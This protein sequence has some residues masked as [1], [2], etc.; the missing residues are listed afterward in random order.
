MKLKL[1]LE[2]GKLTLVCRKDIDKAIVKQ[3]KVKQVS[4][5][6]IDEFEKYLCI[7]DDKLK[8]ANR[9]VIGL[10]TKP[11]GFFRIWHENLSLQFELAHKGEAW[12][13]V[14]ITIGYGDYDLGMKSLALSLDQYEIV[15]EAQKKLGKV[16]YLG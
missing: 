7:L 6:L 14:D 15:K 10:F 13:L 5:K 9:L 12:W 2:E 16:V 8:E 1:E 4:P 11:D 3:T